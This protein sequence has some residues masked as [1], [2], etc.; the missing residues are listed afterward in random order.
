MICPHTKPSRRKRALT[1]PGA[2]L[3]LSLSACHTSSLPKAGTAGYLDEVTAFSVGLAALQVG[4]DV[5]ADKQLERATQLA[6]G[7]PA[8]W[9]NWGVLALRQGNFDAAAQRL[10][11]AQTLTPNNDQIHYLLGVLESKRGQPSQAIAELRKA[12]Q[13]NPR[14]LQAMYLLAQELERQGDAN[15]QAEFQQLLQRILVQQPGNLAALFELGRIAA[16]R[17]DAQTLHSTIAQIAAVAPSWPPEVQPQW[18]A[19]QAAAAGAD[20]RA[21]AVR[22]AF[23]RNSMMRVPDFRQSLGPHPTHGRERGTPLQSLPAAAF[24]PRLP[25][26]SRYGAHLQDC[27][28]YK[29]RG[30]NGKLG[31]SS[32]ARRRRPT[33]D[34]H[35]E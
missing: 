18:T 21:A 32:L 5:R 27:R 7:E 6:D 13:S 14:N 34:R 17:G 9:A 23:L 33:G 22:I 35:G 10:Q 16:K 4:D 15:G 25:R 2:A 1:L 3:A 8:G 20:P 31:W 11:R 30:P 29:T 19:L 24:A 26:S 28:C 12:L